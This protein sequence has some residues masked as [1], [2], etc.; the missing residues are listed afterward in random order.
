MKLFL[1]LITALAATITGK[2]QQPGL[3]AIEQSR[4]KTTKNGM[5]VL[6]GWSAANII[7]GAI[8]TNT[9]SPE[10][11]YFHQMNVMWGGVNILIAGLGYWS[12]SR[13][14]IDNLTLTKLLTRQ[15]SM[16]KTFLF[17]AGLDLAY[18]TGGL[19]LTERS[20]RN[21]NPAKLKGYG[22]SVMLQGGG[23]LLFD[24]VMYAISQRQGKKLTALTGKLVVVAAPAMVLL[25]YRL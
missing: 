3:L 5:L 25:T 10:M 8:G 21:A 22:N 1:L 15:S 17:N 16:E 2:S 12:A 13:E 11:R 19:Y 14:S 6:G 23:L 7:G 18:I 20:R 4:I 9:N 24:A